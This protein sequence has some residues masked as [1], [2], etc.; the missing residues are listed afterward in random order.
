[1]VDCRILPKEGEESGISRFNTTRSMVTMAER[2][3][4]KKNT[5]KMGDFFFYRGHNLGC[6]EN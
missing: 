6:W 5:S 1:M 2:L 4:D 3:V